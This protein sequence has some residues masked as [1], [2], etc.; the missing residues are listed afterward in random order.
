MREPEERVDAVEIPERSGR[1]RLG[2]AGQIKKFCL[3]G[4][5]TQKH[6]VN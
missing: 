2:A 5:M 3:R 4:T 6:D 1:F